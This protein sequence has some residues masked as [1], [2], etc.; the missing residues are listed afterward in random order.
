MLVEK[1]QKKADMPNI[2]S[3]KRLKNVSFF[4]QHLPSHFRP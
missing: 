3:K 2:I 4:G 1:G